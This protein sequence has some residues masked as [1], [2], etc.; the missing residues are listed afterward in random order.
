M[1]LAISKIVDIV[2]K[3]RIKLN[4][5]MIIVCAGIAA[6]LRVWGDGL[7]NMEIGKSLKVILEILP[8]SIWVIVV[9]IVGSILYRKK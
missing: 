2:E 9:V 5:K 8:W 3:G 4:N 1:L 7:K 6:G